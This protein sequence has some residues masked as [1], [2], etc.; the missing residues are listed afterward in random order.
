M[1]SNG[2]DIL[3]IDGAETAV[4]NRFVIGHG[5]RGR[6]AVYQ[7]GGRVA[8]TAR[9]GQYYGQVGWAASGYGYY[10]V[11]GG[12]HS[13]LGNHR[14]GFQPDVSGILAVLGGEVE[15]DKLTLESG[16][17]GSLALGV[18][19]SFGVLYVKDGAFRSSRAISLCEWN[20][21]HRNGRAV[22]TLDGPGALLESSSEIRLGVSS[23]ADTIVNLNGGV[24]ETRPMRKATVSGT[25]N[26]EGSRAYVNFNGGTLRSGSLDAKL[27]N[28][29]AESVDRVTVFAGGATIDT[30]GYDRTF[31]LPLQAP[32]GMGVASV[33]G[34]GVIGETFVGPPVVAIENTGTS[35]GYGATAYADFDSVTRKVTGIHVTS[36]GCNYTSAQAVI[37]YGKPW[38]TNAVT[39][40]ASSSGGLTKKG[41]GTL[42]LNAANSFTGAVSVEGGTLK[43]GVDGALPSVAPV[44]LSVGG[45]L[46]LN[47]RSLSCSAI[48]STGG[49]VANGTLTLPPALTVDLA[50]AKAGNCLTFASGSFAFPANAALTLEN[51][52]VRNSDDKEYTLLKITGSGSFANL[53]RLTNDDLSPWIL[54]LGNGGREIRLSFPRGTLMIFR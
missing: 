53:P 48:A 29:G 1:G 28:D 12:V 46:D 31:D 13:L 32:E 40:A 36:P 47:G 25:S 43:V 42:T 8:N 19:G 2:A 14:I 11:S 52:D 38:I 18:D 16:E 41:E 20:S 45:T 44:S 35:E 27:I 26:F 34:T 9:G 54:T 17:A 50:E 30:A 22:I 33:D 39:L 23:Y 49:A 15:L 10:E 6:G 3:E 4:T 24:L 21:N 51:A 7:R 5:T 37:R